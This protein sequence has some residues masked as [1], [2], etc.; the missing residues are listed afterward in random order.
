VP[1]PHSF[2]DRPGP[3]TGGLR[4]VPYSNGVHD[5]FPGQPGKHAW[6]AEAAPGGGY[7]PEPIEPGLS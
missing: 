6:R 3:F 4:L 2:S 5:A 7:R 1:S